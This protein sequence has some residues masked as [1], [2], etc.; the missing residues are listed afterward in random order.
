M[1][2][3]QHPF[4]TLPNSAPPSASC[5]SRYDI[6]KVTKVKPRRLPDS[7]SQADFENQ[8]MH[9]YVVRVVLFNC[10]IGS[11]TRRLSKHVLIC[12][13]VD[14]IYREVVFAILSLAS[15][16]FKVLANQSPRSESSGGRTE[17][18]VPLGSPFGPGILPHFGSG[19]H[20]QNVLPGSAPETSI[21]WFKG[22]LVL[23]V[24][25]LVDDNGIK[26]AIGTA[27]EFGRDS[28]HRIFDA[29]ITNI[30]T[31]VLVRIE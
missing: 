5:I 20:F 22:V 25:S 15:G 3:K 1:W 12:R 16:D 4:A 13:P 2:L 7:N 30:Q 14:F 11:W 31:F 18:Q 9:S 19:M 28:G 23:L 6:L 8:S 29:L 17:R 21:Y 24:D 27:T 10:F 26:S